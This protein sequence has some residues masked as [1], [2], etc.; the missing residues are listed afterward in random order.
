MKT[1]QF[2]VTAA[3]FEEATLIVRELYA[4]CP[5]FDV[6]SLAKLGLADWCKDLMRK[7]VAKRAREVSSHA[8]GISKSEW[9]ELAK[10][11][12][13]RKALNVVSGPWKGGKGEA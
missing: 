1:I 5:G 9:E 11:E 10:P 8:F 6:S 4:C 2:Q 3:E 13:L 7:V 12:R